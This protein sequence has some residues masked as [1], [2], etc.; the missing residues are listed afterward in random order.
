MR[1]SACFALA[2]L[3]LFARASR[4]EE[5]RLTVLHTT[6]VHGALLPW[7]DLL[8][9]AAPRG[10]VKVATLVSRVRGEG[11]P[12]LLLD[13]GDATSGSPLTTVWQHDHA[14]APEPVTL[15]MN[16]M[17][18]DAMAL[19]NHEFDFG[20]AALESTRA[21][22]HFPWLAANVVHADGS[23]AFPPA[24]VKEVA[25]GIRVGVFG[26]ATPA[27]PQLCD[28]AQ[29]AG[30]Q[31]LSPI[32]IA[33]REVNRLRGAERCDVVIAL[34]HTGLEKDPR[35]GELRSG[36]APGENFGWRLAHEVTGLDVVI[37]GHTHS[38][39]PSAMI[40][41][42]LVTQAGRAAEGLGRIDLTLTR[43]T[44]AGPWKLT[45]R[46]ASVIAL[47]DSLA[48]DAALADT[49][50][51]YAAR[52]KAALDEP[53]AT[54][55]APLT[56][57]GGRFSDNVLW[58][59]V[60]RAQLDATGADVS[61]AALF[62]PGQRIEAGPVTVRDLM[63]LYPYENTLVA[64]EMTGAELK[65]ALEQSARYLADY[66]YEDGRPLAV[67]GMPGFNFDMAMGV[68]YEVDLTRP[69]GDRIQ[70]LAMGNE[71]LDPARRLRVAVNG[72]RAA[73]GGDF[74]M[75]R[76][77]KIMARPALGAP[78][79][80]LDFV[81]RQRTLAPR[82]EASWTLVP[83]YAW[84][85][86]RP[87]IDRL[88]RLGL[89]P[90][91]EVAHLIPDEPARRVDLAYWLGRAFDLRSRRP[92]GAFGDVPESIQV[93]VD[94]ILARG[95]L[96]HDAQGDSFQPFKPATVVTALDWSERAAREAGF[97]LGTQKA[98]DLA[99]WRGLVTGVS[100]Q[101]RLGRGDIAFDATL[102]RAQWLGIV[103]NLRYPQVRVLETT[104]FHGAI[105]S[106]A[107]DRRSGRG[108][109]GTV[110]LA[111]EIVKLRD[112]NPEGTVLLDGGDLF[113][114]TMISNLQFGRPVVEQ[115][116][117]LGY[118]ALAI[119]NHDYDW[120]ADTLK[121]RAMAMRFATLGANVL[122]RRSGRR[123]WWVRSDTTV[124]RRGV[125]VGVLGLAYPG[126]PRV[127]LA[128]NVEHLRFADDSA[129]AAPI[130]P[131]LRKAGASVVVGVGHIPGETDSTRHAR[132]DIARLAR[133]VRG[134]D[135][136]L[137]GHSHNVIDDR[138]E[139][140]SVMI[141]GALGQWVAV[142]DMTVDPVRHVVVE[143]RQRMVQVLEGDA[144]IDSSWIGRVKRWNAGIEPIAA[145]VIGRSTLALDR[146]GPESTI[147]D[148]VADAMRFA[149][150]AEIAMQNP[151]GLRADLPAG[152]L[153]RGAIYGVMPF[154]NTIVMEQLTGD[155]IK[156]ALEQ[157]LRGER[158]TQVSGLRYTHDP[159]RPAGERVTAITLA[160]GSPLDGQKLYRVAVN[161]FMATGGDN[162]D[163][164]T[165]GREKTDTGMVIRGAMEAYVRDR[166]KAGGALEIS[167]DGRIQRAGR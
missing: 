108:W 159:S 136:W 17:G 131:R 41:A 21:A 88:V 156:L 56:E 33:Q 101:G 60:H 24:I 112:E 95:V 121:S 167:V 87:L 110:N 4:A 7:D 166:C 157:G 32:E 81:R 90:R 125:K 59:L 132:G 126:T 129:S 160:D 63:R 139:D 75:I 71:P 103:S 27:V 47:G 12:V 133:G 5:M 78:A 140:A 70:H 106:T 46:R 53:V 137:G 85:P 123:P 155:E 73:G 23:P 142:V 141:A 127:T 40:D 37:L 79:A 68:T 25:G 9:R 36:D 152:E 55:T 29:C 69:A 1:R 14:G 61:L 45:G 28:S 22:A 39:V 82:F 135:A 91:S 54:A 80:L 134:V 49:L 44:G 76:H 67:P 86:E 102:T 19:G 77:A 34:A 18:Y 50:A 72:Y 2:A 8:D 15:A 16:A 57:P 161:N 154:D 64:V 51:G 163:V 118:A 35:T 120:S 99:F 10:L 111:A 13:A 97:A 165:N 116:N 42:T 66:T 162:F 150:G 52:T 3:L 84:T 43:E 128:I 114:G 30:Y 6:D 96:G 147:G 100:L 104:D 38:T 153:T 146:H 124:L 89:A 143:K 113:Q 148:F 62:D 11:S 93:W 83:D 94:G 145:E 92:S 107:R 130:V 115:M 98:G 65:Q 26:L 122:E 138:I 31:F 20:P 149:S 105:L 48:A 144:P 158:V 58:Q 151:G 164:L 119:G 117:L 74:A 109:G